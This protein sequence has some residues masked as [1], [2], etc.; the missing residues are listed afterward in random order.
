MAR[1][2]IEQ[3]K[4]QGK[5]VEF[6][7]QAII[8]RGETTQLQIGDLKASREHCKVFEQAGTWSVADLNSRNG[9]LVNGVQTTR[10]TLSSGDKIQIG[11]TI[12][13][14]EMTGPARPASPADT[15]DLPAAKVPG[16]AKGPAPSAAAAAR[17]A[18]PAAKSSAAPSKKEAAMAEAR[19]A[20]AQQK[21]GAKKAGT[22]AAAKPAAGDDKGMK[23]SDHVLQFHKIDAKKA[24]IADIDLDQSPALTKFVILLACVGFIVLILWGIYAYLGEK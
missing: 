20:A 8:G 4:S 9:L 18:A 21:P 14:F 1:L 15:A 16:G 17:T 7:K 2:R 22:G 11:E 24:T 3:G 6:D 10:K 23:V 12:V 13:V 19:A 5:S